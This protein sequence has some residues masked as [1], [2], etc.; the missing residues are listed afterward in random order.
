MA[1]SLDTGLET[2]YNDGALLLH[3]PST[4]CHFPSQR[5]SC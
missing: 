1:V 4:H 2:F 5:A 3:Q